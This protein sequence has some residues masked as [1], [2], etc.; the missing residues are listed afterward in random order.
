V[1]GACF[2]SRHGHCSAPMQSMSTQRQNTS[3]LMTPSRGGSRG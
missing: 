2:P 3:P 1:F